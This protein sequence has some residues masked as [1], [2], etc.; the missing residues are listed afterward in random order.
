LAAGYFFEKFKGTSSF[1]F[2]KN[3]FQRLKTKNVAYPFS[4]GSRCKLLTAESQS[5]D[6]GNRLAAIVPIAGI[7]F[8]L[9]FK[10]IHSSLPISAIS[11]QRE[12]NFR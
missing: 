4:W 8:P 6:S 7:S 2:Q 12:A 11:Q 3:R 9:Q 1:K 10:R 5:L